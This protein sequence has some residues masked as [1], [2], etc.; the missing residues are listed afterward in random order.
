[1]Y[2]YLL[3]NIITMTF[4]YIMEKINKKKFRKKAVHNI[5]MQ[6]IAENELW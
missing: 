6:V 5:I 3:T 1:M 2:R 4:K